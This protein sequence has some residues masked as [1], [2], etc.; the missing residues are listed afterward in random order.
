MQKWSYLQQKCVEHY[1]EVIHRQSWREKKA[2]NIFY[3]QLKLINSKWSKCGSEILY[4]GERFQDWKYKTECAKYLNWKSDISWGKT[5][6]CTDM[7]QLK[8]VIVMFR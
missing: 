8:F 6:Y 1:N 7:L 4:F 2:D 3:S 5:G